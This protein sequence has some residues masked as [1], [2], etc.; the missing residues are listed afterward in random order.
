[1]KRSNFIY[2]A[3]LL[4]LDFLMIISSGFLSY[5]LRKTELIRNWDIVS[6]VFYQLP[7][8][9][10]GAFIVVMGIVWVIFFNAAGLY[11]ENV[12]R[13]FINQ[14]SKIVVASTAGIAAVVIFLFF[15]REFLFSSRFIVLSAWALTICMVFLGRV[16]IRIVRRIFLHYYITAIP[17]IVIG[18][19]R[20]TNHFIEQVN[21]QRQ[22]GYRI[23]DQ[24]V[25]LDQ[26]KKKI[27][28]INPQEVIVTDINYSKEKVNQFL[29]FCQN[30]HIDFKYAPDNFSAQLHNIEMEDIAG[31]PFLEIK[32]T[33]LEGWGKVKKRIADVIM[34]IVALIIF[35]IPGS[36]IVVI[37]RLTS[38]G[39]I[40]VKLVR[41]GEGGKL[42]KIYKFR[43]MVK[44]AHVMKK[45][46]LKYNE[47]TGPLFKIKKDPRITTFGR[48]LRRFSLD[49]I[50]NFYNVLLGNMSIVG[51]RPHEPE[52]VAQYHV[53]FKKLL[54]IKPGIT[55]IAQISGRSNLNFDEEARLDLYYIEN[56]NIKLD[57]SII[58][59][60]PIAVF[61]RN[62]GAV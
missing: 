1:V 4:P 5:E 11:D 35:L 19:D 42:F 30:H 24:V 47:R 28:H 12:N 45:Y 7:A 15:K 40:F 53:H 58:L 52:E 10:Y 31:F 61:I 59:K 51:P 41:V 37:I 46:L 62:D 18:N 43:S 6:D 25:T 33:P 23:V 3:L 38:P 17:I 49:E 26:L 34:S 29:T 48:F 20:T 60:T 16:L 9:K 13:K 55:G 54:T 32:R 56:W 22:W 57:I 2:T 21:K 44:D 36:I 14:M 8:S 27:A 50:P 39:E